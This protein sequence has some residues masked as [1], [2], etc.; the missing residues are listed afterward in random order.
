MLISKSMQSILRVLL[1]EKVTSLREL[2]KLS[3]TSLGITSKIINQLKN[4]KY[5]NKN[6]SI[7]NKQKLII[8]WS[9]S[10][11]LSELKNINF[12]AAERPQYIIK[13]ITNLANKNKLKYAFTLYSATEIFDPYVSPNKTHLYILESEKNKWE[14]LL[15]KN[16]FSPAEEGNVILFLVDK[17]Y[18]YQTKSI[19]N[20]NIISTP[21]LSADLYSLG[22]RGS[23]AAKR[24]LKNV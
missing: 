20:T 3:S 6:L 1:N 23:E 7:S 5:I 21:Q 2:S 16:G 12:I 10:F 24:L 11:S 15:S 9:Y 17:S 18:F 8:F 22:G 14:K 4:S 19:N 13:K